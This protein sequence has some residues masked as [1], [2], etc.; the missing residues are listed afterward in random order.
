MTTTLSVEGMGCEGCEDIVENALTSVDGVEDAS[1]DREDGTASVEGSADTE[2]LLE[3]VEYAGYR[4]EA[5][6]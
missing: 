4:A 6:A 2:E 5:S 3:A 1:A